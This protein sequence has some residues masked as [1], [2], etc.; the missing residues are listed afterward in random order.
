MLSCH[1]Q[2]CY[3]FINIDKYN[4]SDIPLLL[5]MFLILILVFNHLFVIF[6]I[7]FGKYTFTY[8]LIENEIV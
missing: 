5:F 2:Q 1:Q 4:L 7:F 3:I 6:H 8:L